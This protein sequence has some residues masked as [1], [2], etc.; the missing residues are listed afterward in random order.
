L[1]KIQAQHRVSL[2]KQ[3]WGGATTHNTGHPKLPNLFSGMNLMLEI[4]CQYKYNS[5]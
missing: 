5:N 3:K 2:E 1:Q 4:I